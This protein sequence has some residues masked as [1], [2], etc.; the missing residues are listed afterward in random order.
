MC[1]RAHSTAASTGKAT[2]LSGVRLRGPH[3][4]FIT[5]IHTHTAGACPC[6]ILLRLCICV[7]LRVFACCV[8]VRANLLGL[9]AALPVGVTVT[10][11]LI[12]RFITGVFACDVCARQHYLGR[13]RRSLC[14]FLNVCV[15]DLNCCAVKP[16]IC[17]C[18]YVWK[19]CHCLMCFFLTCSGS[20]M[21]P[22]IGIATVVLSAEF[23]SWWV[24]VAAPFTGALIA[25]VL[26]RTQSTRTHKLTHTHSIRLH[27]HIGLEPLIR[28]RTRKCLQKCELRRHS[29]V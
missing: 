15:R 27:A 16:L 22:A 24:W 23:S 8:C 10:V 4:A 7:C 13:M 21:N 6:A 9:L 14:G 5:F 19:A 3:A 28:T 20:L 26:V 18:V 1:P 2:S 11:T 12:G 25:V 29:W 17:S